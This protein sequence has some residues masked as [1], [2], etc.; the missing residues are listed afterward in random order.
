[1]SISQALRPSQPDRAALVGPTGE[2]LT[3][4]QLAQ[5][6]ARL[7]GLR[8]PGAV[9]ALWTS[10][11]LAQGA[12]LA[13]GLMAGCVI[14]PIDPKASPGSVLRLLEHARAD[15]LITDEELLEALQEPTTLT[16]S[17]LMAG[18]PSTLP[19]LP[20]GGQ[21]GLLVYTSGSTGEPKGVLLN[22]ALLAANVCFAIDH[23]GHHAGSVSGSVM[24]LFHT[25]SII[26]DLL[27]LL[28]CGG[29]VVIAEGFAPTQ[30]GAASRAFED[31]GVQ[32][33]SGVPLIF[34]LMLALRFPLPDT[35]RFAIS[36]AAPLGERTR[37]RY[38]TRYG[39]PILPCYGLT[40]SV[41]FATASRPDAIRPGMVGQAA[42]IELRVVDDAGAPLPPGQDGEVA[43]RGPSVLADGYY[44]DPSQTAFTGGWFLTGDIG[45]LDADGFLQITG[46]KKNMLIRGGEKVYLEDV[47]RCLERHALV[48][49]ACAVRL[50]T[51]AHRD[52]AVAF[53]V[54]K[55]PVSPQDLAA[56][57]V[58]IMGPL[59]RLDDVV[60]V[61]SLPRSGSGKPLRAVLLASYRPER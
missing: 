30:L 9:L 10:D 48:A 24:P 59:A 42:G 17:A 18:L 58:D 49:E 23:F 43:L 22:E 3:T 21:G 25:F 51:R 7:V 52:E 56:F 55:G 29:Q 39:H 26:S 34:D 31:H 20:T 46:R 6:A 50:G 12:L 19:T 61:G 44:R 38:S 2:S 60:L 13:A 40:E 35:L 37:L 54:P 57:V 14:C 41:C 27:A 28:V 33:Y 53:V 11:R 5:L 16:A 1:M 45:R 36:G 4:G 32:T 8:G 15:L 47:E